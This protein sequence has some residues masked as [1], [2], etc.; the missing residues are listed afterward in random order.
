MNYIVFR[1]ESNKFDDILK[2]PSLHK[3]YKTKIQY[4]EHLILGFAEDDKNYDGTLSY[5]ILRYGEDM[6]PF[7]SLSSDRTPIPEVDYKPIRKR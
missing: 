7:V 6:I 2:D 1:R 5:I 3:K 4:N